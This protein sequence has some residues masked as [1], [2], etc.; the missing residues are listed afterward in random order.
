MVTRAFR[1]A[2]LI[3][4]TATFEQRGRTIYLVLIVL[5]AAAGWIV[6]ATFASAFLPSRLSANGSIIGIDNADQGSSL[7][8]HYAAL[9][10][11]VPGVRYLFYSNITAVSCGRGN[12]NV[13]IQGFGGSRAALVEFNTLWPAASAGFK[14]VQDAWFK[15]PIGVLVGP[16]A[17]ADCGWTPGVGISPRNALT[18]QPLAIHVTGLLPKRRN[19]IANMEAFGHFEYLNRAGA[20]GQKDAVSEIDA[21]PVNPNAAAEVAARI[22]AALA[23]SD[24]PVTATTN[25]AFHSAMARYGA[26]QYVLG[27]VM[28]AVF[29]CTALVLVSVLAHAVGERRAKLAVFQVLGF[30][31]GTLLGSFALELVAILVIGAALGVGGGLLVVHQ[32]PTTVRLLFGGLAVPAWAW[33]GTPLWLAVLFVASLVVPAGTIARLRPIDV[34]TL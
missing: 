17:A 4:R 24:P 9:I 7:P 32:L 34:R 3:A 30:P 14:Q 12:T 18:G 31:R 10:Q 22:E 19:P 26:A 29:L 21:F 11:A 8:L 6:L 33:W 5:V 23:H 13:S 16:Q 28:L 2:Y 1:N 25:V 27:Y 15:D 20:F